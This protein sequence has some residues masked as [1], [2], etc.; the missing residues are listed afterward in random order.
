MAAR[1]LFLCLSRGVDTHRVGVG[2]MMPRHDYDV[3][4]DETNK[5]AR[6]LEQDV[7]DGY[8]PTGIETATVM[9]ILESLT[10]VLNLLKKEPH[11]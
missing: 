5:W 2:M 10:A 4:S 6:A 8:V 11:G 9:V 3:C 1:R 7:R